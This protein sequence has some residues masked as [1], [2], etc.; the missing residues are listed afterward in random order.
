MAPGLVFFRVTR[1]FPV[2]IILLTSH[3]HS[4]IRHRR[5]II[6]EID[7][8]LNS[9]QTR[10][11]TIKLSLRVYHRR[12]NKSLVLDKLHGHL[13]YWDLPTSRNCTLYTQETGSRLLGVKLQRKC[14][15][16]RFRYGKKCGAFKFV[17]LL[18]VRTSVCMYV[19]TSVCMYVRLYVCMYVCMQ[20]Q[21]LLSH[22]AV[23]RTLIVVA[24]FKNQCLFFSKYVMNIVYNENTYNHAYYHSYQ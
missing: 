11:F 1:F 22:T 14:Q 10:Q 6:L 18:H 9:T 12:Q 4:L 5:Y 21:L 2:S 24:P 7:S 19:C 8:A 15:L 13:R 20:H 17:F 16:R 23:S 3:T